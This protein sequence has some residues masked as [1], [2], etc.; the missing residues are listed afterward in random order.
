MANKKCPK[1]GEENPAEAVMCWAC[2]TPLAGGAAAVAGGG[3]VTPR[4]GAAAVTP[5]ATA[6]AEN[7]EKKGIDP[8][9]FLVIGLLVG[10][11]II[12]GFTTGIFNP[13]GGE[14]DV[15]PPLPEG[16]TGG[17]GGPITNPPP[18]QPVAPPTISDGGATTPTGIGPVG[19]AFRTVV[20]P[21]P[22]YSNGTMGI[23]ATTPNISPA[24][25][26]YLAKFAQ[27]SIAPG[28]RWTAMQVVVFSE[29]NAAKVFQ[30]YQASRQGAKLDNNAYQELAN[31]GIWR[32]VPAYYETKGKDGQSFQPSANP[33]NWWTRRGTR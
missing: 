11:V 24:Q 9:L 2:Y 31:Q 27:Q 14:A 19:T 17:T 20:P 25:A 12:G 29:P 28:G 4:G 33:N 26:R 1:C 13:G 30:K 8:K 15:V 16:P 21:N 23:M 6:A 32:S 10:A 3:L 5:A 22:R 18:L 7:D